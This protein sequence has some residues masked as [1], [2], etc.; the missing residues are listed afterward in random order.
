MS[1]P[2]AGQSHA[3]IHT[4]VRDHVCLPGPAITTTVRANIWNGAWD[5]CQ[6]PSASLGTPSEP[7]SDERFELLRKMEKLICVERIPQ[8]VI[9]WTT[10][11]ALRV[12]GRKHWTLNM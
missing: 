10:K 4:M 1:R 8:D 6:V 12:R 9:T 5:S 2:A 11:V 7:V 3:T